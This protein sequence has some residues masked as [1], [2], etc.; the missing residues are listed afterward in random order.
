MSQLDNMPRNELYFDAFALDLP[1]SA[2]GGNEP[3]DVN[4]LYGSIHT[5]TSTDK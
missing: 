3:A 2:C 5:F 4:I 1:L